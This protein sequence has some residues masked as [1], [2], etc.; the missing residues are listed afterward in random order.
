MPLLEDGSGR[1]YFEG[2]EHV[3]NQVFQHISDVI[4]E[5]RDDKKVVKAL[6]SLRR[7]IWTI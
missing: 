3:K 4:A 2:R 5:N 6:I 7:R 1:A